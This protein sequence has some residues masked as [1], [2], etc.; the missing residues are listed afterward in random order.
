MIYV[1]S[2]AGRRRLKTIRSLAATPHCAVTKEYLVQSPEMRAAWLSAAP[3]TEIAR[4]AHSRSREI[5]IFISGD[6]QLESGGEIAELRS[7]DV[8]IIEPGEGH[9]FR[10]GRQGLVFFAVVAPNV[11]DAVLCDDEAKE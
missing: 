7:G 5:F 4:H 3:N 6:C 9:R 8:A 10:V 1:K 2:R 11:D